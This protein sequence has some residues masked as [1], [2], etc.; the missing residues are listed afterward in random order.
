[1][2]VNSDDIFL[3][4]RTVSQEFLALYREGVFSAAELDTI[5]LAALG[6]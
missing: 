4:D 1:M 3:F 2:T 5:R 6:E